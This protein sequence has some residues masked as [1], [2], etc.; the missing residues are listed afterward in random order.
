[1]KDLLLQLF[2]RADIKHE[3][4]SITLTFS[5]GIQKDELLPILDLLVKD[6]EVYDYLDE[7]YI[8]IEDWTGSTSK[9]DIRF[10]RSS[11][12]NIN[13]ICRKSVSEYISEELRDGYLGFLQDGILILTDLDY[14][15]SSTIS[16]HPEANN[17]ENCCAIFH[18][19]IE[20]ADLRSQ[21][22][23]YFFKD[24]PFVIPS[25]TFNESM[26]HNISTSFKTFDIYFNGENDDKKACFKSELIEVVKRCPNI[27][28]RATYIFQNFDEI[29]KN[30]EIAYDHFCARN[31]VDRLSAKL[32]EETLDLIE[33]IQGV[34]EILK[35]ELIVLATSAI[36]LSQL[37]LTTIL[38]FRNFAILTT[39][40][41]VDWVFQLVIS[42]GKRS[43]AQLDLELRDHEESLKI[44]YDGKFDEK[45]SQKFENL[46]Q[47]LNRVKLDFTISNWLLWIPLAICVIFLTIYLFFFFGGSGGNSILKLEIWSH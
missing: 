38:S 40:A 36:G 30:A 45:I 37:D 3:I 26:V 2:K 41:I 20:L 27:N 23:L 43:I 1:M 22:N 33:R 39:I 32:Q 21:T 46:Q 15:Q 18:K 29:F 24:K 11:L 17:A 8:P 42:N 44:H 7:N 9:I 13:F 4:A 28:D 14:F 12:R 19:L 25:F 31:G 10:K 6:E 16:K 5:E 47:K 34:M 35:S